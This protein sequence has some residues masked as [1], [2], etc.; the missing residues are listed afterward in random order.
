MATESEGNDESSE[1]ANVHSAKKA[2]RLWLSLLAVAL[3]LTSRTV[4]FDGMSRESMVNSILATV[5]VNVLLVLVNYGWPLL[6]LL[7]Y[8]YI[9]SN[10]D[11][12]DELVCSNQKK[13]LTCELGIAVVDAA[14][15]SECESLQDVSL[16]RTLEG[17]W[18]ELQDV[19]K[20]ANSTLGLIPGLWLLLMSL[21]LVSL[22][23]AVDWRQVAGR[24]LMSASG[25]AG[26]LFVANVTR[27]AKRTAD[28]VLG[29][30]QCTQDESTTPHGMAKMSYA[31]FI[32]EHPPV[33]PKAI[34]II[35]LNT[36]VII[37]SIFT[38][39][40]GASAL[41]FIGKQG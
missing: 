25:G 16:Q 38:A 10:L 22:V 13:A 39:L 4:W 26:M 14:A 37:S 41:Y 40:L 7:F 15:A 3:V 8:V 34:A 17:E 11:H 24:V 32:R 1:E 27:R 2:V 31:Q 6:A 30:L 9:Q 18:T 36:I 21:E 35:P 20:R 12:V 28:C 5:L 19:R 33:T 29:L 23:V